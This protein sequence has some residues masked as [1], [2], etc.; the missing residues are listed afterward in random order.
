MR[1]TS[2]KSVTLAGVVLLAMSIS[3]SKSQDSIVGGWAILAPLPDSRT[4]VSVTTDGTSIFVLGGFGL[5]GGVVAPLPVYQYRP[6]SDSWSQ[7]TELPIGVNHTGLAHFDGSLY[8]IGGFQ[9]TSFR[10][11]NRVMIFDL[12]ELLWREGAP[13]PT[14]RGALAV[15]VVDGHIHAIGGELV[16]GTDTGAHEVYDPAADR[17]T[18][19]AAMPSPRNHHAAAV[20]G[21]DIVVVAGRDRVTTMLTTTEIFNAATGTWRTGADVPTGR[22]GVAA[23]SFGDGVYLFGGEQFTN[24]AGTFADVERY[25]PASDR[26]SIE[27]PMPTARHGLGAAAVGEHIFVISGGPEAGFAFSAVNERFTPGAGKN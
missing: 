25:R 10:A 22:S 4:E 9:G 18:P 5:A 6:S 21:N 3:T 20:V 12:D 23:V 13:M 11:T 26:W 19:A 1:M 15:A 2:L 24:R 16:N 8:V 14:A 17:W 27:A 7:L